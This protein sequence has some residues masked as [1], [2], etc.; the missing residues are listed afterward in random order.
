MADKRSTAAWCLT[1]MLTRMLARIL[2]WMPGRWCDLLPLRI[3]DVHQARHEAHHEA[4]R[5]V[6]TSNVVHGK[7][8]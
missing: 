3:P 7:L 2:A 1:R 6:T 5:R 4:K 8:L